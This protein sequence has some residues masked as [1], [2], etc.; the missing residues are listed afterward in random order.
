MELYNACLPSNIPI[1]MIPH[2][3]EVQIINFN[4][5]FSKMTSEICIRVRGSSAAVIITL[6]EP[7]PCP[8]RGG[9]EFILPSSDPMD[10]QMYRWVQRSL[11]IR[12][13]HENLINEIIGDMKNCSTLTFGDLWFATPTLARIAELPAAS[14]PAAGNKPR[15]LQLIRPQLIEQLE[16]Y[17][18]EA[19]MLPEKLPTVRLES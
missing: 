16:T 5:L 14:R 7:R 1:M 13:Q 17:V 2:S 15:I 8:L 12:D 6:E 18:A 9:D 11:T 19:E 3:A 4:R 10:T